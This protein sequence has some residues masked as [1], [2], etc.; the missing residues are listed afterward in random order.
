MLNYGHTLIFAFVVGVLG[1]YLN[2]PSQS[3]W[4]TTKKVLRYLQGTKDLMLT[5]RHTDTL[6]VVGFSDSD[7]AGCVDDKKSTFCYIFMMTEIVVSWK[8]VKQTLTT[9]SIIKVEFV[10]CYEATYH[11][12]WLWNFISALEVVH[13]IS[14]PLKL[15]YNNF[16][17]VS[18]SKNTMST[19]LSK[20]IHVNFFFV[21]EKVAESLISVEHTN[22]RFTYLCVSI[23]HHPHGI[24]R[25]LNFLF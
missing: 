1:R 22:Q 25:S 19:S 16:V 12:I 2:D 8:S 9:S 3:H 7:Y 14:R 4:K 13:F 15:L 21:K 11:A 5:Y 17:V 23:T 6:E 10:A 24:V 18:F 20:P